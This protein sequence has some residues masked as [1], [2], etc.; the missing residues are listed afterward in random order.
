MRTNNSIKN[1]VISTIS[2]A[3]I[4]IIGFIAQKVFIITLGKEYLG[5]NGLFSN[6]LSILSV[7]ELGFGSAI[8]FHLYKPISENDNEK[9]KLLL[10]MYKKTY[11][12]IAFVIL[13]LG[14]GVL[15][16]IYI[17]VGDISLNDNLYLLFILALLEVVV[18]YF[19]SYKRSILYADQKTYIVNIVH[20]L[21][22]VI[23]NAFE[24]FFLILTHNYIVYLIIKIVF[25]VFENLVITFIA[26]KKYPYIIEKTNGSIS[27]NLKDDIYQKVKGLLYHSI[28]SALVL[29]TD[30]LIISNIFGVVVV[31]LYSNYYM[32]FNAIN[33]L[34]TQAFSSITATIGNLLLENDAKK[35]YSIYKNILF[36]N[37]WIY[38][39]TG[40]CILCMI[41]PFIKIWLGTDFLLS[42]GVL[43]I[44]VLNYYI[45]GMRK[46]NARFK[47]A[48][49]IFYEDR[50]MPIFE[51]IV[52]L[53]SSILLAKIFGLMGVFMG[54]ILSSCV[55]F[56]YS[57]PIFVYKKIFRRKYSQFL[58]EHIKY[59]LISLLCAM[60]CYACY[61]RLNI[62]NNILL[63]FTSLIISLIIPN[64]IYYILYKNS[65]E[66]NYYK[67]LLK[68]SLILKK[69]DD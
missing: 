20:A 12:I 27:N 16:F 57:Y 39:I 58:K 51:S 46:T 34:I 31:G 21:Y 44:L 67:N 55:L 35:S 13:L 1:I 9:I 43:I 14:I 40:I 3:I 61:I 17:I 36:F 15:P 62:V 10:K 30:N 33:V 37:S 4:I 63:L 38:C 26:N 41:E 64:I 11:R 47:E 54:T 23:L 24:I 52:N 18:S 66:F 6:I 56:F 60:V 69:K 32:I 42:K 65:D 28:A 19:L 25:K 49:G 7:V 68:K 5:L 50:L 29:S 8:I 48:A 22:V 2:N 45:Q 53:I 59:F